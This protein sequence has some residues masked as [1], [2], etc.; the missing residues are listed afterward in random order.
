[1][2]YFGNKL[3]CSEGGRYCHYCPACEQAHCVVVK[4]GTG[5]G[6]NHNK[7][8]P[9]FTPSVRVTTSRPQQQ[10]D[11][12]KVTVDV[13]QCHYFITNGMI[14]YCVDSPHALAGKS[15]PLPDWPANYGFGGN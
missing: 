9:T 13:T 15:V 10:P 7:E 8:L 6:F 12:S 3:R 1:M 11:G 4:P 5:W 14:D 2:S